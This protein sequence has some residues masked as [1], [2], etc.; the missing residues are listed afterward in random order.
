MRMK[1]LRQ[2]V[3]ILAFLLLQNANATLWFEDGI[4]GTVGSNMGSAPYQSGGSQFPIVAGNL[5]YPNLTNP[6]TMGNEFTIAGTGAS[7]LYR[8]IT[9]SAITSGSV[10]YA[11]LAQ[12]TTLPSASGNYVTAINPTA[13]VGSSSDAINM[14]AKA[15]GSGFVL[16]VR[17]NGT[18][19]TTYATSI[20]S[21]NTTYLVVLKYTFNSG[22][23]ADDTVSIYINPTPG[24]TEPAPDATVTGGT[25]A[26]SLQYVGWK[27]QS[28][29]SGGAWIFDTLR[30][31]STWAEAIPGSTTPPSISVDLTNQTASVGDNVSFSVQT[32][33]TLP[34][35]YEW[36]YNTNTL[37]IRW[38]Q[39]DPDPDQCP[40]IRFRR[41]LGDRDQFVWFG[42]QRRGPIDREY[43]P[44]VDQQ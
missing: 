37:L 11:F 27:S 24:A 44:P 20:L 6:A 3:L 14:S 12:C 41:L 25:D 1:H 39:F 35:T 30:V 19:A 2:T 5:T 29:A 21:L 38:N 42:D 22:T 15:S 33:G 31:A 34:L 28:S 26:A 23:S 4:T 43:F 9:N 18:S 36:Y 32:A 8:S 16:G 7:S 17:K 40:A 10:Y 13:A